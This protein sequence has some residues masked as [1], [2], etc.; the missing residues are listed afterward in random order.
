MSED[1]KFFRDSLGPTKDCPPLEK[2]EA[3]LTGSDKRIVEHV[4]SCRYC[5]TELDMLRAFTLAEVPA[6]DSAAVREV[7]RRLAAPRAPV[8]VADRLPWWRFGGSLLRPAM[9]GFAGLLMLAGVGLQL[10]N[11]GRPGLRTEVGNDV[12]RANTL[13][14]VAPAGDLRQAPEEVRWEP[15]AA[16]VRYRVRIQEVDGN[17]IWSTES[18]GSSATLPA[19]VR[20]R[21]VPAKTLLCTVT[22]LDGGG[23]T[24]AESNGVRFRVLQTI[25]SR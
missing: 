23:R 11:S 15:V 6:E 9:L 16:A 24:V 13:T 22:A 21:I 20:A 2:L 8:R 14:V 19:D 18:T 1:R 25:Y 4:R 3:A 5:E 17:Q 7:T 10:R 12:Y